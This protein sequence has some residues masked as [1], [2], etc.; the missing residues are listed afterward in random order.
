[1]ENVGEHREHTEHSEHSE[2][3]N[4]SGEIIDF[5]IIPDALAPAKSPFDGH[6]SS[7]FTGGRTFTAPLGGRTF[8]APL[9]GVSF[10]PGFSFPTRSD[11]P[12]GNA[13]GGVPTNFPTGWGAG[14]SGWGA[15][16]SGWGAGGSF[17]SYSPTGFPISW[18]FGFNPEPTII[19]PL[20]KLAYEKIWEATKAELVAAATSGKTT[21]VDTEIRDINNGLFNFLAKKAGI[22]FGNICV[23]LH[24]RN[25]ASGRTQISYDWSGKR[26]SGECF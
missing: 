5:L 22:I 20:Q 19:T 11:F 21:W 4:K 12:L 16:G 18:G 17:S 14:G 7:T 8:T 26:W 24:N 1:V 13:W 25:I 3:S 23:S 10:P 15:G 2:K 9:G 6:P